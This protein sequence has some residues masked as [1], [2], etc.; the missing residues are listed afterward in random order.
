MTPRR[1]RPVPGTTAT[2][3]SGAGD[4]LLYQV[5]ARAWVRR[6]SE[7]LGR[8]ATLDDIP[9]AALDRLQAL[10][11]H[12]CY[13]LGVWQTG[14]AA[15]EVSRQDPQVRA[16]VAAVLPD[17]TDDDI[18]GSCFAITGYTVHDALGGDAALARLRARLAERGMRLM[19]DFVP[20]HTA[21]DH[22]WSTAHPDY[23]V[24]GDEPDLA[25]RP[26]AFVRR[27]EWIMAHG[28]DPSFAPWRDTLQLDYSNP[29]VQAAMTAELAAVAARADGIRCDM[30][31]LVLPDVFADTWG[32]R[33]APF[34]QQAIARCR[35][36]QP[37]V[38]LLAEVYWDR[39]EEL[40]DQGF[41][42]AYDKRLYDRLVAPSAPDVRDHLQADPVR[43]RRLARFLENHDEARAATRFPFAVHRAATLIAFLTP[44]L[45]FIHEG[46][47]EGL[48]SPRVRPRVP[49]PG[50]ASRSDRDRLVRPAARAPA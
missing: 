49:W 11:F 44:G 22:P 42:L 27:G 45:S 2:R 1:P 37:E 25:A 30:A 35:E 6:R 40:L 23:Y 20:N 24:L 36:E 8:P 14:E 19:V 7:T 5:D 46:Q 10:G 12:W 34:W 15:R 47:R 48:P 33:P 3:P 21:P 41:D 9:S 16:A 32:R 13:L 18:C 26:D 38:T 28:R 31:M 4:R 29:A 50:R 17:A 39:E 43:Q